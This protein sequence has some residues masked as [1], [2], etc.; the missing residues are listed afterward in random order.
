[1][2]TYANVHSTVGHCAEKTSKYFSEAKDILR[3]YTNAYGNYSIIFHGQGTTGAIYKLIEV[4]SI[5]KYVL[6]YSNL[7]IAYNI[8]QNFFKNY[9]ENKSKFEVLC[10]DLL[11][12]IKI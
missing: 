12:Q 10:S 5:K 3:N 4:L 6:F 8:K 1:M 9:G 2:P 7:E 11:N